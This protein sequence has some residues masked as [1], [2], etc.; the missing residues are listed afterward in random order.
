MVFN[1][2]RPAPV[3]HPALGTLERRLG[4]WEGHAQLPGHA[5]A[6]RISGNRAGPNLEAAAAVQAIVSRFQ[7]VVP[8]LEPHLHDHYEAYRDAYDSGSYTVFEGAFPRIP[9]GATAWPYVSEVRIWAW[10][11]G[12]QGQLQ[13]EINVP[14]DP[15]HTLGAIFQ[16]ARL[17]E[18]SGSV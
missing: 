7:E 6:V 17:V 2:L 1:W 3:T 10:A 11:E 12:K 8:E 15:E 4:A 18:F 13:V 16:E 5:A 9:S 14:W